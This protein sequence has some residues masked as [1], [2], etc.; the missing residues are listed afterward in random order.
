VQ[1]YIE[2]EIQECGCRMVILNTSE[3]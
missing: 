2:Q 3:E 1:D